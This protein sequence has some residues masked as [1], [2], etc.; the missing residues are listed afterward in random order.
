MTLHNSR[1]KPERS[2][3]SKRTLAILLAV[4]AAVF[5]FVAVTLA[6]T[7]QSFF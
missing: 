6:V 2:P 1:K 3:M 5:V 7:G 4:V